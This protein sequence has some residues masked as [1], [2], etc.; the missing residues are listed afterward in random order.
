M[1]CFPPLASPRRI[2][3]NSVHSSRFTIGPEFNSPSELAVLKCLRR[4]GAERAM[5]APDFDDVPALSASSP[6][7]SA[8]M[9]RVSAAASVRYGA[10]GPRT[11]RLPSFSNGST[12][13]GG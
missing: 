5:P 9:L 3:Q 6:T 2:D 4:I 13:R 12:R 11:T 10:A 1:L 7:V 8:P